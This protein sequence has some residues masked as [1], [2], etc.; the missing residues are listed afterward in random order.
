MFHYGF[1]VHNFLH[2]TDRNDYALC[3]SLYKDALR[4]YS[5][6]PINI[7]DGKFMSENRGSIVPDEGADFVFVGLREFQYKAR[8]EMS[9]LKRRIKSGF[10]VGCSVI[11]QQNLDITRGLMYCN[12]PTFSY[13]GVQWGAKTVFINN[14][15]S[16]DTILWDNG[17]IR[18]GEL[19]NGDILLAKK[20]T[21]KLNLWGYEGVHVPLLMRLSA[22]GSTTRWKFFHNYLPNADTN[23]SQHYNSISVTQSGKIVLGGYL[24]SWNKSPGVLDTTGT[25]GWLTI[26][27]D[28]ESDKIQN[29]NSIVETAKQNELFSIYPNPV[30]DILTIEAKTN[31]TN[32]ATLIILDINGR[33][34]LKEKLKG[35][36]Q[37]IDI[38]TLPKG[39]YVVE[40]MQ[41]NKSILTQKISK[42]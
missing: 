3:A 20:G 11:Q 12:M 7:N 35:Q 33:Q 38:S 2:N 34:L 5:I 42:Q 6:Y 32:N 4:I 14:N 25:L 37:N 13:Q 36:K 23:I 24:K 10:F 18:L 29:P 22:D 39:L 27:S 9:V 21:Y 28:P 30:S 40:I 8:T 31:N 1:Q 16:T 19:K 15:I 41:N 17:G 26:I